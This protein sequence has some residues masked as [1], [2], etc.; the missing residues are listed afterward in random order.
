MQQKEMIAHQEMKYMRQSGKLL[1]LFLGVIYIVF[2][3]SLLRRIL[4]RLALQASAACLNVMH[5]LVV[6]IVLV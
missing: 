3:W 5:I 6:S 2:V 4:L 1:F